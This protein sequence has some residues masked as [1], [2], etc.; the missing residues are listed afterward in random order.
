MDLQ[1]RRRRFERGLAGVIVLG[2]LF[3]V[4]VFSSLPALIGR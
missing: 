3:V 1:Q 2:A 4:V